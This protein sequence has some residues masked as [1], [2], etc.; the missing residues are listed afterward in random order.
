VKAR[1]LCRDDAVARK[2]CHKLKNVPILV[3][4]GLTANIRTRERIIDSGPMYIC[5][6]QYSHR[7][8]D[9]L[10]ETKQRKPKIILRFHN[11]ENIKNYK[12]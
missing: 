4:Y 9:T 6:K 12:K 3:E 8:H 11:T 5:K 10:T 2:M 7:E 1:Y